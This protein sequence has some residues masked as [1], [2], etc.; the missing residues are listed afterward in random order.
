MSIQ[1]NLSVSGNLGSEKK[2]IG[3]TPGEKFSMALYDAIR[4]AGEGHV[5]N[6]ANGW[7]PN[8]PTNHLR[9]SVWFR[10][11]SPWT[12][13]PLNNPEETE[14]HLRKFADLI[15][16]ALALAEYQDVKIVLVTTNTTE[17]DLTTN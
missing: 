8:P 3:Y 6:V 7:T 1:K 10:A 16:P 2:V 11:D 5:S 12:D 14:V 9:A 13:Q 17:E 15:K 4:Q